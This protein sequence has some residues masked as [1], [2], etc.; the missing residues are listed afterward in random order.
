MTAALRSPGESTVATWLALSILLV[1]PAGVAAQVADE[2]PLDHFKCYLT[3]GEP[4]QPEPVTLIDQFDLADG[5]REEVQV[6]R[7]VRFCNPVEKRH[8][9]RVTP[10][11]DERNHL[12]LYTFATS[13]LVPT[14]RVAVRNQF[15]GQKLVVFNPLVL[16][17]PTAK[18]PHGFPDD[19]DHFKC[20]RAAGK[21]VNE[22]VDLRDQFHSEPGV[23]VF[24]PYLF[25]NPVEK[26]HRGVLTP[27]RHPEAHLV[28]YLMRSPDFPP[29]TVLTFNQFGSETQNVFRPDLLCVPSRKLAWNEA[30]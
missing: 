10:I 16:A 23:R 21:P 8:R 24:R 15:G 4:R 3:R 18:N 5:I 26:V 17:V 13:E 28:C 29:R 7:A 20:Y 27:I 22:T 19:L 6:W 12:T 1:L 2:R 25:C 30:A 9:R 11:T 14:R